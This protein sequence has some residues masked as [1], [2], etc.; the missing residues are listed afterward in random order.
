M[1]IGSQIIKWVLWIGSEIQ[2]PP[3]V[4]IFILMYYTS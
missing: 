1:A 3:K 2:T 4:K